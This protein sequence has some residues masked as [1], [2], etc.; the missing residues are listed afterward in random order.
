[1][2]SKLVIF[3]VALLWNGDLIYGQ[4]LT[5][6]IA[7]TVTQ[8]SPAVVMIKGEKI[9]RTYQPGR[10]TITH[11]YRIGSG[12]IIDKEGYILT[13]YHIIS[14][15]ETISVELKSGKT[16]EAK[17]VKINSKADISLLKINSKEFFPALKIGDSFKVRAGDQIIIIGN[18]LPKEVNM[19]HMAFKHSVSCGI[20]GSTERVGINHMRLF[21]LSLPVN[22]GNSGGPL[23]NENGEVIGVVNS[24]MLTFNGYPLEGVGFALSIEEAKGI[25]EDY[26]AQQPPAISINELSFNKKFRILSLLAG[27]AIILTL[28]LFLRICWNRSKQYKFIKKKI[29]RAVYAGDYQQYTRI[30][31]KVFGR[32]GLFEDWETLINDLI[33]LQSKE[34]WILSEL[35]NQLED[36]KAKLNDLDKQRQIMKC[37]ARMKQGHKQP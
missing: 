5:P 21:Q 10:I 18:P 8:V 35:N 15:A 9:S 17:I 34:P 22:F 11:N 16:Y 30:L 4:K 27:I 25:F 37:Q 14:D 6:S 26:T 33:F 3:I 23:L 7:D 19:P 20:I 31:Q 2:L 28:T 29:Y 36:L 24:K 32:H 1:M 12:F 13:C